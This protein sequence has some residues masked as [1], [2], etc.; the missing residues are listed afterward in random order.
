MRQILIALLVSMSLITSCSHQVV[1]GSVVNRAFTANPSDTQRE[2]Q[3]VLSTSTTDLETKVSGT[4]S[5][6]RPVTSTPTP[7]STR[8]VI[9]PGYSSGVNPL[10]GLPVDEVQNLN[11]GPVLVSITNFPL[12]ARPQS[13]LSF[14]S[15]VWETSIGEGMTR[16]IAVFYGDFLEDLRDMEQSLPEEYDRD[17]LV[18]PVRS[19]RVAFQEIKSLY[20]GGR[21]LIRYASPEVIEQLT[22]WILVR[23]LDPND[24]N[25]AGLTLHD[26][27]SLDIPEVDPDTYAHLTFDSIPPDGGVEQEEFRIIYN[28]LN[29][30]GWS[31]DPELGLYLRAQDRADGSG[32]LFPAVERL[33]GEQIGFENVLLLW[34][35]HSFE[36]VVGTI[37]EI[38]LVYLPDGYGL[39]WRDGKRYE[40]RWSTSSGELR[41]QDDEGNDFPLK[42]GRTI[43]EVVSQFSTWDEEAGVI[44][45]VRPALPTLTPTPTFTPTP[46]VSPSPTATP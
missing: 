3:S 46:P 7:T 17:Y 4:P 41:V 1:D 6:S 20:P 35:E 11:R 27:A 18:G 34:T 36:N 30:V 5:P 31:Y 9:G 19:G 15:H 45:Y 38:D 16:F 37:L 8:I 22:G 42:P 39:L 2:G 33:N 32:E 29:N 12:S 25:S 13:G 28:Y 24:I 40:I 44:R 26:L 14:A 23:A 10:T 21:L 43:F